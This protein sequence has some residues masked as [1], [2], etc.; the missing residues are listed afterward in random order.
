MSASRSRRRGLHLLLG[1]AAVLAAWPGWAGAAEE[2]TSPISRY[3]EREMSTGFY[4][5]Y[6]VRPRRM[7]PYVPGGPQ[8]RKGVVSASTQVSALVGLGFLS[9][10]HQGIKF[11]ERRTCQECHPEQA[12]SM[13]ATRA[14]ITC[15][16]CHG[17]EPMASVNHYYSPLN[18]IR[19]H[20]YVCAKC[21]AGASAS[22]A[23]YVVH[24]PLPTSLATQKSF[25]LLFYVFWIM[26][27][28]AVGTFAL[29]IPHALVW[30]LREFIHKIKE[31]RHE[32]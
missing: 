28:L 16:Q 5:E 7:L 17:G 8:A 25:P 29:F 20:A 12:R 21:H 4:E 19:R 32:H 18:P 10:A 2:V 22:F 1:L 15:R 26:M 24:E 27:A 13:H 23:T 6:E 11:Y 30:G 3:R 31:G 14:K 9:D